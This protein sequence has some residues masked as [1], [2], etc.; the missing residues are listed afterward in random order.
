MIFDYTY[1]NKT[2]PLHQ[3][4]NSSSYSGSQNLAFSGSCISLHLYL[5]LF[6]WFSTYKFSWTSFCFSNI[7]SLLPPHLGSPQTLLPVWSVLL[8][9]LPKA[10]SLSSFQASS[11]ILQ[12]TFPR[13]H[14]SISIIPC[15]FFISLLFYFL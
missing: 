12:M 2:S 14:V 8:P 7:S 5:L 15:Q 10:G 4:S 13:C 1:V 11:Q 3:E 9:F 6:L